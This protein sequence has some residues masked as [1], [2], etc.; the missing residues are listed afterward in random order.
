MPLFTKRSQTIKFVYHFGKMPIISAIVKLIGSRDVMVED[1]SKSKAGYGQIT[2]DGAGAGMI[3]KVGLDGPPPAVNLNMLEMTGSDNK[4]LSGNWL[5][6]AAGS[7]TTEPTG[8]K[9][10]GAESER[11]KAPKYAVASTSAHSWPTRRD[12]SF[13]EVANSSDVGG[14]FR[15]SSRACEREDWADDGDEDGRSMM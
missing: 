13:A 10:D 14:S 4:V 15:S 5:E 11:V 9:S 2:V 7:G 1:M 8:A 3:G 6:S 12:N